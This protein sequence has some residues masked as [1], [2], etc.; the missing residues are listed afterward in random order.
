[1]SAAVRG[2]RERII[3]R[4]ESISCGVCFAAE[5]SYRLTAS[6]M[7]GMTIAPFDFNRG[8][9]V[10]ILDDGHLTFCYNQEFNVCQSLMPMVRVI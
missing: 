5:T 3:V 9:N 10:K 6:K 2:R 4:S 8:Q 7:C 1:M